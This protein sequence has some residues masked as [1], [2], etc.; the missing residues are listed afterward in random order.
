MAFKQVLRKKFNHP[1]LG[2]I[3]QLEDPAREE[4]TAADLEPEPVKMVLFKVWWALAWR[5]FLCWIVAEFLLYHI[6]SMF[7]I[8]TTRFY[9]DAGINREEFYMF[10]TIMGILL[11]LLIY[12]LVLKYV[13][14][15][16]FNGLKLETIDDVPD[17]NYVVPADTVVEIED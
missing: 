14:G 15:K 17:N 16:D 1:Q 7:L 8:L 5:S 11:S 12:A 2:L 4:L 3:R 6:V 10:E 9:G 13:L